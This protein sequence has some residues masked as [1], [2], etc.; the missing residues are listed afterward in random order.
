MDPQI[1]VALISLAGVI[2]S[3]TVGAGFYYLKRQQNQHKKEIKE[4]SEE[5]VIKARQLFHAEVTAP[6]YPV[7]EWTHFVNKVRKLNA[8][9]NVDRVLVLVALNGDDNP[10]HASVVWEH[11]T[12]G[13]SYSYVDVPLD[14]D[15]VHR[16]LDS[17][18]GPIHFK[19]K[20]VSGTLIGKFYG[21][22]GVTE[23][24]WAM[25]GKRTSPITHQVAYKYIS[26]ATHTKFENPKEMKRLLNDLVAE[27][28]SIAS[29]ANF[30]P[31]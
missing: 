14:Q 28:R 7:K 1:I 24:I 21:D 13:E 30:G 6:Y 26:I 2:Y 25:I 4:L 27:F 17:K 18:S 23:S 10:S 12:E 20:D 31:I 8:S 22:E 3:A 16:L 11:R 5:A 19:T 15:Y 9:T 29:A